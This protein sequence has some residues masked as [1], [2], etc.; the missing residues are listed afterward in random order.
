MRCQSCGHL[1]HPERG[2]RVK[3]VSGP[4]STEGRKAGDGFDHA[5]REV[6]P[7]ACV[8]YVPA[9]NGKAVAS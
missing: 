1:P 4:P 6:T 5:G 3:R 2:C 9:P 8:E 7:C